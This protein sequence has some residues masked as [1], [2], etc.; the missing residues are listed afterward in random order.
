MTVPTATQWTKARIIRTYKQFKIKPTRHTYFRCHTDFTTGGIV[1]NCCCPIGIMLCD[2]FNNAAKAYVYYMEAEMKEF[3][4]KLGIDSYYRWGL[5]DAID[6]YDVK[7][8]KDC[9]LYIAHI[10]NSSYAKGFKLGEELR[11]SL[12][13]VK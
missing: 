13:F 10:S 6:T 4:K 12:D 11:K 9:P 8:F 5:Q 2:K 1:V 3:D 7:K